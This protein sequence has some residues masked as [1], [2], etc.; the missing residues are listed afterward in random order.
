MNIPMTDVKR[1]MWTIDNI[2]TIARR[3]SRRTELRPEMWAH[4][5]RLC[6]AVGAQT[7]AVGIL[8]DV[9][10]VDDSH[11]Q[12]VPPKKTLAEQWAQEDEERREP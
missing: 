10:R 11:L 4:V 6:E 9:A 5:L 12:V 8:R 2:Y 3:E 1:L 7:R